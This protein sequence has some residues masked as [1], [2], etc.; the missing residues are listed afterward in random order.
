MADVIT[1]FKL[2]TTQYDSKLR[3][4]AKGL[5]E[6]TRRATTA[7]NEFGKFT[8]KNIEAARAFGQIATS[9]TNSK[10]KVKELV[11]AFNEVAKQ[12]NMLTKEQQQSDFGKALAE[13]MTTLKG[14]IAEAKQEMN[15]TGGIMEQFAKKITVNID[16]MKLFN[17]GLQAAKGAL[18]VA[19]DAFFASEA[20]VDEWGRTMQSAQG[21]YQGFLNA[22]NTGD[23]S[24]YLTRMDDI[25][26]AAR[27]A[28]NAMDMLQTMKTIQGPQYSKQEAE[29]NRLRTMLMTGRYISPGDGR[30]SGGM[31][32]GQLLTPE[33]IKRIEGMLQNGMKTIVTLTQ[34]ELKQTGVAIDKYYN[35]LAKQN[36]MSLREFREGTSS[37]GAFSQKMAGY[38]AYKKWDAQARTDFA[39]Q[40][41]RG[42][43][44]F[45]KSNPYA[46]FRKWGTFRVDKMGDNS[47]ND[48]V[49][50]IK[51]QQQQQSQMYSTM[52]QAY[53]TINRAEGITVKGLLNGGRSGGG[54]NTIK[55]TTQDTASNKVKD[56]ERIY[57]ETLM[58]NSIRLDAGMDSTLEY[59]KR[60][61]SAQE[62][63]FDAYNDA[64]ATYQDPSYKKA[65]MEAA[66]KIRALA[67][68]VKAETDAQ[69]AAKKSARELEAA[70]KK[71]AD[72]QQ[73]LADAQASGSATA[74]YKAQQEVDKQQKV[75]EQV[76]YVADVKAIKMP[77][78]PE[79]MKTEMVVTA[80][81]AE[82]VRALQAI[83]GIKI[84]S[85]SFT[86]S[87]DDAD[88]MAKVSEIDGAT[89]G[90]K[91]F[92]ISTDNE[93]ALAKVREIQDLKIDPKTVKI[94]D[95]TSRMSPLEALK[96]TVQAEIKFDQMK[97]DET[98]LHT[99]LQ[100]A[101]QNGLDH[102]TPDYAGL[103]ER[104]AKGIDIPDSTWIELQNEINEKLKELGIDPIKIN[105]ET[106]GVE[107]VS[108]SVKALQATTKTTAQVV[109]T[110]GQA[111]NAIEDPAAKV[112]A[113]VAQAIANIALAYS[114]S[115]AKDQVSKS[116]IFAFI[117]AAA[118]STVSMVSTI[119]SI[120]SATGYSQGGMIK[121]NSYSGDNIGGL[122]DGSQFVG[123]N[124]GE[125][126]L[127]AA[128]QNNVA[129]NLEGNSARTVRVVGKISGTDIILSADRTL[130]TQGKQLAVW[131]R[132]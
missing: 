83:Q 130:M 107:K 60:E 66:G 42:Y 27:E 17:V 36:G 14:R 118:A 52:G 53:R 109:G 51:Q 116:N 100:T 80:D 82:A 39:K 131:G 28:Y 46:E 105:L 96:Q 120:H 25:V 71:L 129:Q 44:D 115:L 1:R 48:L 37:W 102:L 75:V 111:F 10:D 30:S 99:L 98:T 112:A 29:N 90:P 119:A 4:A 113:V 2:E 72:A 57:A 11:S 62:R 95:D 59:K 67:G 35:S 70:Q 41:G 58:K 123:L 89:I 45:D 64:Y 73:K 78:L 50:L 54:G 9:A 128:Q 110:I 32:N 117:A 85:K 55:T 132:G 103:Q 34:N 20:N 24:G 3:D 77:T 101:L 104:I 31:K 7:G 94:V 76:Q 43:V 79:N 81:T 15:S 6:Y 49:G 8:Q 92:T 5:A 126:V 23:I 124:A 12:Y 47:Y 108:D 19:K 21:L 106:G 68:E 114:D 125:L 88:A 13:S 38:E 40:G 61:L 16:A 127:N 84:D 86:V 63:L 74:V 97:V 91:T 26:K 56:A 121:G 93:E 87:T 65:S 122:V 22:I 69:E 18:N 33:Q